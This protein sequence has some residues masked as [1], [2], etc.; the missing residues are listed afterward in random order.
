[1]DAMNPFGDSWSP[2]VVPGYDFQVALVVMVF[3][4][5][6]ALLAALPCIIETWEELQPAPPPDDFDEDTVV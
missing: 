4:A 5:V 6:M 3:I 1:M 2:P